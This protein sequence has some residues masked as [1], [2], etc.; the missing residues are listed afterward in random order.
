MS[1]DFNIKVRDTEKINQAAQVVGSRRVTPAVLDQIF[2]SKQQ[3]SFNW[4]IQL[5]QPELVNP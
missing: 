1:N 2:S 3:V 5:F 4:V